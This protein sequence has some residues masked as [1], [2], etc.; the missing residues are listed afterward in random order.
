MF[1]GTANDIVFGFLTIVLLGGL[2]WVSVYS[3]NQTRDL[4]NMGTSI[5]EEF[6]REFAEQT[7]ELNAFKVK[8]AETYPANATVKEIE[9]RIMRSLTDMQRSLLEMNTNLTKF[10]IDQAGR[11][12]VKNE[13]HS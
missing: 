6:G 9:E 10:Y 7:R 4:N 2:G 8:I 13:N 1:G 3:I 12:G 11:N 5:R